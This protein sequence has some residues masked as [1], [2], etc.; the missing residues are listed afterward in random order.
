ML[1]QRAIPLAPD[2]TGASLHDKLARM[3][4]ELLIETLPGYLSGSIQPQPQ[5]EDGVTFAPQIE[6]G[7]GLIDW[8]Q[9]AASIERLVRAFTPWPGTY[10][11]WNGEPLKILAG[12]V[13]AGSATPGQV[14]QERD[15]IAIGTG[16]GLF[17]VTRLQLAG[18]K[19]LPVDEFVRGQLTFT[20]AILG[21]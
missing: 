11:T 2:E 20:G 5:P 8:T 16:A 12:T 21:T 17:A 9:D 7:A 15:G 19:A 18:R 6:K 3:G 10:T 1:S 4:A 14:I 13:M